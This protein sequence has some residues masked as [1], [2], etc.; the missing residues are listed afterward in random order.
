LKDGPERHGVVCG[1]MV[2]HDGI[3][4]RSIYVADS[5]AEWFIH[6]DPDKPGIVVSVGT[7]PKARLFGRNIQAVILAVLVRHGI[8]SA[9]L[10]LWFHVETEGSGECRP[11]FRARSV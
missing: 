4:S 3:E 2:N 5:V 9:P 8:R 1:W 6:L 10:I 7:G 11:V